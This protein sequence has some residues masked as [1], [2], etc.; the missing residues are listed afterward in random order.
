MRP[1]ETTGT[2]LV[3]LDPGGW[4]LNM[5]RGQTVPSREPAGGEGALCSSASLL[6]CS[7]LALFGTPTPPPPDSSLDPSGCVALHGGLV[8]AALHNDIILPLA[9][10]PRPPAAWAMSNAAHGYS[11][12]RFAQEPKGSSH[13]GQI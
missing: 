10:P 13:G 3:A 2:G 6:L 7:G 1:G 4:L 12:T 11:V 9:H 8:G 5:Q